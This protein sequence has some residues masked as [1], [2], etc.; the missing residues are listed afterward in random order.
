MSVLYDFLQAAVLSYMYDNVKN[1]Q[2]MG[3]NDLKK[4]I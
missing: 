1:I 4:K 2:T 3:Y